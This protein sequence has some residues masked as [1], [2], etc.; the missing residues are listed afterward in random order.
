MTEAT[1]DATQQA[2]R[3]SERDAAQTAAGREELETIRREWQSLYEETKQQVQAGP[4]QP[5][6]EGSPATEPKLPRASHSSG[7]DD[8]DQQR[9]AQAYPALGPSAA[10]GEAQAPAP[11]AQAPPA[12]ARHDASGPKQ[13]YTRSAPE[14]QPR[15]GARRRSK[16]ACCSGRACPAPSFW[17]PLCS[18]TGARCAPRP[19]GLQLSPCACFDVALCANV[20]RRTSTE[21]RSGGGLGLQSR[22]GQGVGGERSPGQRGAGV[23]RQTRCRVSEI[24][25][26]S[27]F[28]AQGAQLHR[29]ACAPPASGGGSGVWW[30]RAAPAGPGCGAAG[31]LSPRR[32]RR[33]CS[34]R[35]V[36]WLALR[37]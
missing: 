36:A 7:S 34:C 2:Q 3:R 26:M 25:Y 29:G 8:A 19:F 32:A 23:A 21:T 17:R 13:E 5:V 33:G 27:K 18:A 12:T 24:S 10:R 11:I 28:I 14:A 4:L 37:G 9:L 20:C 22:D 31:A 6:S 30:L 1:R 16:W 35:R 15:H